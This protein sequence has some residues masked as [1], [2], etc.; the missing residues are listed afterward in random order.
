MK[1]PG[2]TLA[3]SVPSAIQGELDTPRERV[4]AQM[5]DDVLQRGDGLARPGRFI[6]RFADGS[7]LTLAARPAGDRSGLALY[8]VDIED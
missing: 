5:P 1:R 7:R 4:P 6:Y 2:M 8:Y 3:R